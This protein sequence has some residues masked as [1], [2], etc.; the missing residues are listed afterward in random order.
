M[1]MDNRTRLNSSD[2]TLNLST[3]ALSRG[4]RLQKHRELAMSTSNMQRADSTATKEP[5]KKQTKISISRG[6]GILFACSLNLNCVLFF[7]TIVLSSV[8]LFL[9]FFVTDC[10]LVLKQ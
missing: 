10:L 3:G 1:A 9:C 2:R 5:E 7:A 6:S 4:E 8:P